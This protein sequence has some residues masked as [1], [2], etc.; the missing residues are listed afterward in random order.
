VVEN[1]AFYA[2]GRGYF[3]AS[4]ESTAASTSGCL[5]A[6][7]AQRWGTSAP[8]TAARPFSW[9]LLATITERL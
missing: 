2:C 8:L 7:A 3:L 6:W 9:S 4:S 1:G 5:R